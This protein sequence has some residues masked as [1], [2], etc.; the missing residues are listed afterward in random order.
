MGGD[1]RLRL[2]SISTYFALCCGISAGRKRHQKSCSRIQRN[3]FF[4]SIPDSLAAHFFTAVQNHPAVA[5][6][7]LAPLQQFS[8]LFLTTFSNF[9]LPITTAIS[10]RCRLHRRCDKI[11][12]RPRCVSRFWPTSICMVLSNKPL[13]FLLRDAVRVRH[14]LAVHVI[15]FRFAVNI[16]REWP[17]HIRE[18]LFIPAHP[19]RGRFQNGYPCK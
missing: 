19:D 14:F 8:R 11:K 5:K 18:L 13:R 2:F 4:V 17:D 15:K 1:W 9:S 6:V 12:S 16:A 3:L 10:R 7:L